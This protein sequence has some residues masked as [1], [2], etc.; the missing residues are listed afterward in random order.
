MKR[1]LISILGLLSFWFGLLLALVAF[2][3]LVTGKTSIAGI[4]AI[5]TLALLLA[6]S[7]LRTYAEEKQTK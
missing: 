5:P 7:N 3:L 2:I 4:F 6:G 1:K